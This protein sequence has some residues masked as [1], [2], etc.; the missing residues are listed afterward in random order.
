MREGKQYSYMELEEMAKKA[1][2]FRCFI[3][4]D[5]P[6]FTPAGNI[7]ERIKQYC[8][9][10]GQYVPQSDDEIMRC[11]Y[12]SLALKYRQSI[13]E[14]ETCTGKN[15]DTLYMVGGGTKDRFLSQLTACSINR[16]VYAGPIEATSFGNIAI[17]LISIGAIE[18]IEK[19]RE[20]IARSE[21]L[22]E[23]LPTDTDLW[24]K[25]YAGYL[26]VTKQ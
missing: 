10:T 6:E 8:E 22:Y 17:Q 1:Q 18:N 11:I 12:E 9:K 25:A 26:A 16:K 14:L 23:F 2:P 20:V 3:D 19:A 4:P 13:E 5:A 15:F 24:D 7:P 21:E